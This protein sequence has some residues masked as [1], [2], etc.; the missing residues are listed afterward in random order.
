VNRAFFRRVF[1]M[2][3]KEVAHVR[4]DP[5]TL[6]LAL[7]MPLLLILIFG[8]GIR[9]DAHGLPVVWVDQD[10]GPAA[11]ELRDAV[12]ASGELSI[13]GTAPDAPSAEQRLRA[14]T[15]V[16]AIVV[17]HGYG[18]ARARGESV[19]V[20]LL[21]DGTDGTIA[22]ALLANAEAL[23]A[24]AAAAD[25][26]RPPSFLPSVVTRYNP[27]G[28]SAMF[29]LPG[30]IA[31]VL[32]LVSV[33]LTSLAVARE[34]ERGSMEQ[35]FATSIGTLEIVLGKLLPYL[36]LGAFDVVTSLALGA[37]VF[38]LPI[39]GP[40]LLVG[41][42]SLLFILGMLGQG[43]LISIVT[44]SQMLATQL[45]AL[46]AM[47]PSMLLSGFLFPVDN[48]PLPF[49]VLSTVV[50]ARYLVTV[51]RAALLK[52]AGW[53]DL[54]PQL[55]GLAAFALLAIAASTLTFQRRIA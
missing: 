21:V 29:L 47:L 18:A 32:A 6:Y 3:R 37:S 8:F 7:G 5:G 31:Y 25:A 44:R 39:R 13:A 12:F 42:A 51:L 26:R 16:A 46:S 14:N 1:A 20:Q 27:T 19:E 52:G 53:A 54:W 9:F 30:T 41:F 40:L 10:G 43:L 45:G 35:L 22:N 55:C 36:A 50:P 4:R 33:L 11:D 28:E 17:P 23:V 15:A 24:R 38:G 34:W 2:A 48:L 49:R